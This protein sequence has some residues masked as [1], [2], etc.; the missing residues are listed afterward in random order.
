MDLSTYESRI[1]KFANDVVIHGATPGGIAAAIS[2]AKRGHPYVLAM[3]MFLE[4]LLA[5]FSTSGYRLAAD[6]PVVGFHFVDD[7]NGGL[8]IFSQDIN[9]QLSGTGDEFFLFLGR[10]SLIGDFDIYEWHFS[11]G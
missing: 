9:E 8:G 7:D 2:A 10:D 3:P 6:T 1:Q 11:K 4:N 5:A